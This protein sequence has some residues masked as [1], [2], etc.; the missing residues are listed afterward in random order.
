MRAFSVF[1][2]FPLSACFIGLGVGFA[3]GDDRRFRMAAP[4]LLSLALVLRICSIVGFR[5]W[6]FPTLGYASLSGLDTQQE[7][8]LVTLFALVIILLLTPAFGLCVAIGSRLGVLFDSMDP[9]RAYS[10]NIGGAILGSIAFSV[11]CFLALSNWMLVIPIIAVLAYYIAKDIGPNPKK[12]AIYLACLAGGAAL[13]VWDPP[14]APNTTTYWSPYQRLDLTAYKSET[15]DPNK[16]VAY[17]LAANGGFYQFVMNLDR[18]SISQLP[19]FAADTKDLVS[20]YSL[21]YR[22]KPNAEDVLIVGAGMGQDLQEALKN[23]AALKHLDAVEIDPLIIKLGKEK[24]ISQPYSDPR[25]TPHND[26]ARHFFRTANKKYDLIIFGLLDSHTTNGTQ[27]A[28]VRVDN[29]V[30]TRESIQS[31]AKLLKPDGL[32]LM[33]FGMGRGYIPPRLFATITDALG[34]QPIVLQNRETNSNVK[35]TIFVIGEAARNRTLDSNGMAPFALAST[36]PGDRV[37]TD[38]WPYLYLA[39]VPVDYGYLIVVSVVLL[40]AAFAARRQLF[41]PAEPRLWQMF[42]LGSAFLLLELQSIS[43]LAL[44]YGSTWLTSAIVIN[45]VLVMIL[46]SNLLTIR[47][48]E[49]FQKNLNLV[50]GAL[51]AS[52]IAS[53]VYGMSWAGIDSGNPFAYVVAT[54]ISLL[55][56]GLAGIVFSTSF[57]R[58][59]SPHRAIGFN[60]FG[61]VIGS[62][63]EYSSNYLG[64]NNLILIALGLYVL[65]F[66]CSQAEQLRQAIT[67]Q[68]S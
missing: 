33:C 14:M 32:M 19:S 50:Y 57:S 20:Y 36:G 42:F 8:L 49:F 34:Y 41:S 15:S 68:N 43:R 30:Y 53:Y 3:L 62:M 28:S 6:E 1:K 54:V 12:L 56:M 5:F 52:L 47:L 9:L 44:L 37:L 66:L 60:L 67:S 31:A 18:D 63:L 25:V 7:L 40:L 26:D 58:A 10:I 51:F 59:I 17:R 13:T 38:D 45:G 21:P 24:T 61:S 64:L 39:P 29:F 46:C 22:V 27:S 55:P 35:H 11:L 48:R 23:D 16:V 65:S 2:T 4:A